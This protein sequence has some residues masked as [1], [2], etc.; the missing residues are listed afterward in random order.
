MNK[1]GQVLSSA[2]DTIVV[3]VK[4]LKIFEDHK[5]NF[6]I[7]QYLQIAQGNN[8]FSIAV[9]K[10]LKGVNRLDDKGNTEWFF[11][12]ECQTIG[13]LIDNKTFEKGSISLPV[14][15]EPVYTIDDETLY[16]IFM[17]NDDFNFSFGNILINKKIPFK[18]NGD[19]FFSK[20]IAVVGSTGSGKSCAVAKI[21]QD[22]VGIS[23]K[24]NINIGKQN[25]S[26]IIIFDLHSEYTAA[27]S[28]ANEQQFTLN[29]LDID[30]LKL[31]Y[32]LMNSEELESMF[33][34]SSDE[35]SH[36]NQASM[37]K[38]AVVLNKEKHNPDIA[39]LFHLWK[40]YA[41]QI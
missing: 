9:I 7:G 29:I 27:F 36:K 4:E 41:K 26:H 38:R 23:K 11:T 10:N 8:D 15:T 21:L 28:L 31:P 35:S 24:E 16:K 14:P 20:H 30:K 17:S 13:M 22:I 2:P 18:I 33:I 5:A 1:I 39:F 25:N 3:E 12:I 37:F 6:Q 32:W 40:S 19:K 34:E